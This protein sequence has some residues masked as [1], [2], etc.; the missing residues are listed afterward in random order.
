MAQ[1]KKIIIIEA[2]RIFRQNKHGMDFVALEMIRALQKLDHYNKYIIAVGPGED[3]CL[4]ETQNFKIVVLDSANYFI[5]EQILLPRLVKRSKADILH[6]TSNTAPLKT[7][8]PLVLTLHDIIFMERKIGRNTSTYQN[9]GRVYR[10]WVVPKVLKMVRTVVTVSNFEKMNILKAFPN[11]EKNIVTVYNGVSPRFRPL[12]VFSNDRFKQMEK[13][14]YWLLLGNTDPKKNLRNA[15]MAYAYYLRKSKVKKKL[16]LAD[17]DEE[18]L[19]SLL[20]EFNLYDLREYIFIE[21]YIAHD[22]LVQVYNKAFGFLYPSIRESFGLPLLEAMAS[23]TPVVASNTS[24]IPEVAGDN[25]L[26]IDPNSIE[27]IGTGMLM[28]ENDKILYDTLVLKGMA[29]SKCFDWNK[30]AAQT[31]DI[32]EKIYLSI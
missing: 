28:L 16:L 12:V 17:L 5:W 24:A 13:G 11:L 26:Y 7:K 30:T 8:V 10:R 3:R 6:C 4:D 29:R 20:Q 27:S 15:L 22:L 9:L 19:E 1:K 25:V 14:T 31:L 18:H 23:G 2:Q 21:E 32:Y